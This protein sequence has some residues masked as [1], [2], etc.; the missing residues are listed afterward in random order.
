MQH[1]AARRPRGARREAFPHA[2]EERGVLAELLFALAFGGGAHDPAAGDAEAERQ[3]AQPRP[4]L[5]VFD[6]ARDAA[7]VAGGR[8][9]EVAAGQRDV[10]RDASALVG[11]RVLERLDD[12]LLAGAQELVDRGLLAAVPLAVRALAAAVAIARALATVDSA[13]ARRTGHP[14]HDVGPRPGLPP[15]IAVAR[16]L[17]AE[18][19]LLEVGHL[20]AHVGDVEEGVALEADVDEGGLHAGEDARHPPL[21]DVADDAARPLPLDVELGEAV[22]LEDGDASLMRVLLDQHLARGDRH[23]ADSMRRLLG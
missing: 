23:G 14:L 15:L 10:R 2:G 22:V 18:L 20:L 9:D 13:A 5:G 16:A 4:L 3:L 6:A 17:V 21:V 19:D 7:V 11:Q 8:V 1:G 12:D